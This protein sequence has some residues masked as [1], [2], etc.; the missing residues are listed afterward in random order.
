M[1]E[2]LKAVL[3]ALAIMVGAVLAGAVIFLLPVYFPVAGAIVDGALIVLLLAWMFHGR[4][5]C[6]PW[7]I[8]K[9]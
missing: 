4:E 6:Q 8:R 1:K 5:E 7:S 2:I 3:F 9:I